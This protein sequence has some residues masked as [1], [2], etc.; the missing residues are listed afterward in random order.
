MDEL[1]ARPQLLKQANLSF[2]RKVLKKKKTATRAEI[3]NETD[4]SST[5]IRSLLAEMLQNGEI[6]S[7]GYDASSGGRKAERYCLNPERYY[8][9]AFCI[10]D[11]HL[12]SLV[13]NIYGDILNVVRLP[14]RENNYEKTMI[15]YLDKLITEK[16]I[17]SIGL[18]VP[19]IVRG[20]SYWRQN[21]NSYEM[22]QVDIGETLLKR[23]G[24][25]IVMENDLNAA[26]IGFR[27]CCQKNFSGNSNKDI[28]MGYVYF[29]EGCI[30]AGFVSGDKVIRGCNNFAGELGM[31][32]MDNDRNLDEYLSDEL[33]DLE[34]VHLVTKV[35]GWICGIL[36]PQYITLAG[37]KLHTNCIGPISDNLSSLLPKPMY[38]EVLYSP[39][40][41]N[42]YYN[43]MA[44][45]TAG[46]MFDD[47]QIVK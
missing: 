7:I 47:I 10:T 26:A 6:E 21:R 31:I 32:P 34:Y 16:E 20:D 29:E 40:I 17:K 2:I 46:K 5:T 35:L 27:L 25:P 43:G 36:N 42:D 4:I 44:Y 14:I 12:H 39:D 13:I 41:W 18:G 22:Y 45:L 15:A 1:T 23:Y 37:P 3:A 8:G 9:A 30:S 28:T 19:G 11:S 33:S 38:A 24:I